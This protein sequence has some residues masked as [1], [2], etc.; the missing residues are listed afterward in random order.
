MHGTNALNT[1]WTFEREKMLTALVDEP[2]TCRWI[3]DEINRLCRT[4]FTRNSIISKIHRMGL[5]KATPK[6]VNRQNKPKKPRNRFRP[7][8][9]VVAL[10]EGAQP[11]PDFIGIQFL[12][13][14]SGTCMYPA[15]DGQHMFF[16]GQARKD[17]SSYCPSHHA[18]C[19]VKPTSKRFRRE[20]TSKR[21]KFT[22]AWGKL[23][24]QR[25]VQSRRNGVP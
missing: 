21:Q 23:H 9:I 6:N 13:T 4:S 20:F 14:D 3:A 24:E 19:W 5:Q 12:E 22:S 16:C 2:Y 10:F 17:K 7:T 1:Q 18:I 25:K 11:P 8:R 15:G